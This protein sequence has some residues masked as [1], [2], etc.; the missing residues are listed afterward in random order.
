[1][2]GRSVD[3]SFEGGC[4]CGAVRYRATGAPGAP[5][6]CHCTSCRRAAGA[7]A[8]AWVTFAPER[9]AFVRGEPARHRSSPPVVR[10]FCGRCGTPLTYV[11]EAFRG[12]DVTT[13]S[14]DAPERCP[15]ADH[16]WVSERLRWW[17]PEP[18]WPEHPRSR[19]EGG[20]GAGAEVIGLDHVYLT[21]SDLPRAKRFY[22]AMLGALGFRSA[23]E[24]IGGDPHV[25]YWNR[26]LQLSLR[27]A[28][29]AGARHDPYAPGL[30]HVCL[31][32]RSRA[33]VDAAHE[34]L[35]A[36]GVDASAPRLYP[37]Y[38]PDYYATFFS[39]PDGI[40]LELV[41]RKA[42]RDEIVAGWEAG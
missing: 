15:P 6:L 41:A 37:E 19:A 8:V 22:D 38:N 32:V 42:K 24:P 1:V 11:H 4:L 34:A 26:A 7:P 21:A 5:T 16:T 9:F 35:R 14:L 20:A 23:E 25:H 2:A 18:R 39:D 33:E 17:R 31:Q 10:S 36:L 12:V 28:R 29:A 27:P 3:E 40:R 13:A 30:H